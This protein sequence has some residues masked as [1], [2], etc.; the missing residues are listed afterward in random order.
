MVKPGNFSPQERQAHLRDAVRQYASG[1][2]SP[3][4]FKDVERRFGPDY[5]AGAAALAWRSL[6]PLRGVRRIARRAG[7]A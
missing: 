6:N 5:R 1:Q 7:L 4:E 2:I 3:E